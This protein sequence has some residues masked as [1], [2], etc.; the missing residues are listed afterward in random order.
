MITIEDFKNFLGYAKA[1]VEA[2]PAIGTLTLRRK[3][4]V[5]GVIPVPANIIFEYNGVFYISFS[6]DNPSGFTSSQNFIPFAI[7]AQNPGVSGNV[8][9]TDQ[10]FTPSETVNFT[11]TNQSP[12]AGGADKVEGRD[13][14]YPDDLTAISHGQSDSRLQ[15][16]INTAQSAVLERMGVDQDDFNHP[17]LKQAVYLLA[18]FMLENNTSQDIQFYAPYQHQPIANV[19]K[20]FKDFVYEPLN[21]QVENLISQSGRRNL[22]LFFN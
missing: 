19:N 14:L 11:A 20:R 21:Q 7:K 15:E 4:G 12:I 6:S 1:E 9:A 5:V 8:E 3:Q 13:G 2:T 10:T 18:M 22:D 17:C 16:C